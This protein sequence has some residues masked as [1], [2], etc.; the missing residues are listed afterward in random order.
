MPLTTLVPDQIWHAQQALSFGP[1][2]ITTRMTVV[3]LRDGALW[4]HSPITP[5][6]AL[7]AALNA[8]GPVRFVVAPNKAHHLFFLPF[9]EAFPHATGVVAHGLAKK[10]PALKEYAVLGTPAAPQWA[11]DL[12]ASFIEGLPVLNETVWFHPSSGTLILTDLLCCFGPDNSMLSRLVARV[13][14]VYERLGMS[15]TLKALI[16]DKA[17]FA[18]SVSALLTLDVRRIVLAHDQV[19]EGDAGQ[20]LEQA[21]GWLARSRTRTPF[22]AGQ[23]SRQ[24]GSS[25]QSARPALT[26]REFRE[27][28]ERALWQVM[29]SAIHEIARLHYTPEQLAAWAPDDYQA[30][31]WIAL[32]RSNRPFVAELDGQI[33][34]YADV[35][36]DGYI[37]Q[38]FVAGHA[39]RKGVGSALMRRIEAHARQRGLK[40][41]RSNV[42]LAAQAFYRQFG[43]EIEAEQDVVV[44]GVAL[45]N[46][47][48]VKDL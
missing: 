18:D 21:F 32:M 4:V 11:P 39:A 31:A 28:E 14:G 45:R 44:R 29:R 27:G 2:A 30:D 40:I 41:L 22:R 24:A 36:A 9:M 33:A 8:I 38:F 25:I 19:I 17:A 35:Q 13:L 6:P 46:A 5:T 47:S 43:F 26:V 20:Q 15:P 48:M 34:G 1:L 37:D 16:R 3:R 10:R 12:Q 7:V 23:P 42:S